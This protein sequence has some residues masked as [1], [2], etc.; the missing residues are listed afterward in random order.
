MTIR[1]LFLAAAAIGAV[2]AFVAGMAYG[3]DGPGRRG[4]GKFAFVRAGDIWVAEADGSNPVRLTTHLATDRSPRWSPDGTEIAFSSNRD[5]DFEI[6]VMNADGSDPHQVTF[7]TGAHDRIPSWSADAAQ[8]VYDK[9]FTEI[10]ATDADGGGGE[11]KLADGFVPGTS[12]RGDKVVFSDGGLVAMHIDG[13]GRRQVTDGPDLAADW[14]PRGNELVFTR[15][16]ED[17]DVYIVH[18]NGSGLVRVTDTPH[19]FEFAPVWSPDGTKI[20]FVGCPPSGVAGD[21]HLYV[22]GRDGTGETQ[23]VA[24]VSGGEGAVD[25]QPIPGRR[26]RPSGT[27]VFQ[28]NRAGG[29]TE[30]YTMAEDGTNVRRLTFNGVTDRAPRF[31]PDGRRVVFASDRDGDFDIYV[32]HLATGAVTQLTNN[33][34]RDDLPVFTADGD[35]VVYQRG[36]LFCP[37]SLRAVNAD[38]SGDRALDTGPGNAAFPDM[39]RHGSKLAFASDRTGVWAIYTIR[40]DG[41]RLRQ[42]T[43]PPAGSGDIRPRWSPRGRELV[44]V[45]GEPAGNNDV[46]LIREDGTNLRQLTSGPRFEEHANFSPDG[47]RVIFAVFSADGGARLYTIGRDGTDEHALPPLAAPLAEGFDDGVVD[48]SLWS[49]TVDPGSSLAETGGRLE[50]SIAADAVPGGP[51]N[52]IAAHV[53]S[54]CSLSSDYDMQVEFELLEWPAGGGGLYA[55]LSAFFASASVSRST[56]QWGDAFTAQSGGSARGVPTTSTRGLLRLVR[57]GSTVHAYA[58]ENGDWIPVLSASAVPGDPVIGVG[59]SAPGAQ[60]QHVAARV[61]F[62]NFRLT[63]G[64]FACPAWWR[65]AGPDWAA[66]LDEERE[67][68]DHAG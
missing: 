13:S 39:S 37:C 58:R 38:G 10:Y 2:V 30:L 17:R 51:F 16:P 55:S 66:P 48:A 22:A 43:D 56:N 20:A 52:Q 36:E 15:S 67:G 64:V 12:P 40:L 29:P 41:R 27:I 25:W 9:D 59:L 68:D 62:D 45:G 50:V 49:T 32:L 14:S 11:R 47:E 5:G 7:N 42:V 33:L 24:G 6:F 54:K 34:A 46:F 63:S 26:E 31:S 60:F 35:T 21:C 28:S 18:A 53:G 4:N 65:D 61:A 57:F 8:I 23:V 44:F 1:R 3:D 19:R